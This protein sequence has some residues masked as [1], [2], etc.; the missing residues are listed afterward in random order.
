MQVWCCVN[1]TILESAKLHVWRGVCSL[2]GCKRL[3]FF[4]HCHISSPQW[5]SVSYLC[6]HLWV[7]ILTLEGFIFQS[8]RNMVQKLSRVSED[9]TFIP[10]LVWP[11]ASGKLSTQ[12]AARSDVV[13]KES[14]NTVTFCQKPKCKITPIMWPGPTKSESTGYRW[15]TQDRIVNTKD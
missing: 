12:E 8:K 15:L 5:V 6:I 2:R 4:F 3:F 13:T 1:P 14:W 9:I 11:E 10:K 7:H